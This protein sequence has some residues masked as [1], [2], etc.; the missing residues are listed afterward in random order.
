MAPITI[1]KGTRAFPERTQR[2]GFLTRVSLTLYTFLAK[3]REIIG[4]ITTV[5]T[6]CM[7]FRMLVKPKLGLNKLMETN[8]LLTFNIT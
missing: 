5:N 1:K 8:E 3:T 2:S 6:F 7:L 4:K